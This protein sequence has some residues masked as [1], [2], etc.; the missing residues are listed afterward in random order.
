MNMKTLTAL[1]LVMI[2]TTALAQGFET[3]IKARQNA[4]SEIETVLGQVDDVI[5]GSKTDWN[6]LV[7]VSQTLQEHG[8][9]LAVSFPKGSQNGS[10]AK[11][12]V[13]DKSNK[14]DSLLSQ[15]NSGFE[16]MYRASQEQSVNM[17]ENG[18]KQAESTCRGCHRTYRSRW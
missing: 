9:T 13:W 3:E 15:M 10:K 5:D 2:P 6:E 7:S 17:A 8:H 1:L 4:F 16:E 11:D 12:A 14:F 18:L